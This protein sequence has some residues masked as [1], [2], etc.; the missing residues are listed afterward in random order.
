MSK[1]KFT[2]TVL[3]V[4]ILLA[5]TIAYVTFD[6]DDFLYGV[7]KRE[8]QKDTHDNL[9]RD[10]IEILLAGTGSP[11]HAKNRG[12][13]CLG[14]VGA[15]V[16]LL[17]DAGHGCAGRLLDMEAPL[18][19]ISTVFFTHLHADHVSGLG[20][21][22]NNSWLFGRKT[23]LQVYGPPGTEKVI[24]GFAEAYKPEVENK[25]ALRKKSELDPS[26][27]IA[28]PKIITVEDND[29]HTVYKKNGLVVKAFRTEHA[30]FKYAYGY[31]V[32]YGGSVMVI[33]GDTRFSQQMIRHAEYA[34]IL[35]HEAYSK[36]MMDIVARVVDDLKVGLNSKAIRTIGEAHTS[37]LD[38]AK[39]AKEAGAHKLV[40]THIIPPLP[41]V[42]TEKI[43]TLDM[44]DIYDGEIILAKDGM[45]LNLPM[46]K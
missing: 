6:L 30:G 12:Q 44:D 25:V 9:Q 29:A 39:V 43:F 36:R 2:L 19:Q 42:I 31:R 15:G 20:E 46:K 21:V 14:V 27:S 10:G 7:V 33:S 16:F 41:N 32:E 11:R 1:T 13:P 40:L 45:R 24:D 8:F 5:G 4:F 37:T 23:D 3:P 34:D 28:E 17:F 22:I 35:I 18:G 26:H 38:V